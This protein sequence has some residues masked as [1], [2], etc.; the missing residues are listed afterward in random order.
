MI[1]LVHDISKDAPTA[2]DA[3]IGDTDRLAELDALGLRDALPDEVF[4]RAVR[5]ASRILRARIALFSVVDEQRQTFKSQQRLSGEDVDGT[6]LS[7]SFCQYVVSSGEPLS[8]PDAR[9]HPVLR[10]NPAITDDQVIAYLGVPVRSANGHVVG[11]FC[12]IESEP[13]DW[14]AD[15]L[16]GLRDLAAGVESELRL[17][18]VAMKRELLVG[19]LSHRVKNVFAIVG[20]MVSMTARGTSDT[21]EMAQVLRGR[22]AAL[23]TAH[24][25]IRPAGNA[26]RLSEAAVSL[27]N[28]VSTIIEPHLTADR[29]LVSISGPTVNLGSN[30]ATSLAL[31]LHELATNAAKYGA[32]TAAGGTVA[33]GWTQVADRLRMEWRETLPAQTPAPAPDAKPGF[34]TRLIDSSVRGQLG[35]TLERTWDEDGLIVRLDVPLDRVSS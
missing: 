20:G 8:V 15:E 11:S 1:A 28:L 31:V 25:L 16:H 5:L 2:H 12:V 7:H 6:P 33:V 22:L 13:R 9:L 26:T 35:G 24:N 34:G 29:D 23:G 4:D 17:R 19:E 10:D 30:G 21:A 3:T 27:Q 32:F 18:D 14:T